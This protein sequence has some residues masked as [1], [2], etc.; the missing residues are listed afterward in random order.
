MQQDWIEKY[1]VHFIS[2]AMRLKGYTLQQIA[3]CTGRSAEQA[4]AQSSKAEV[5]IA[6]NIRRGSNADRIRDF[7]EEW[8]YVL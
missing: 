8:L 7:M 6:W 5:I 3:D 4:R 2:Y 1:E